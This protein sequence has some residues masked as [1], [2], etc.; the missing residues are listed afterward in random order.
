MQFAACGTVVRVMGRRWGATTVRPGSRRPV[1]HR[2]GGR[3]RALGFPRQ[4]SRRRQPV[5]HGSA[6]RTGSPSA[7]CTAPL[8]PAA[9]AA[10]GTFAPVLLRSVC[11]L[12]AGAR[13]GAGLRA[14]RARVPAAARRRRASS[15]CVRGLPARRAWVPGLAFGIGFQFVLLF[16]MRAVGIG[17]WLALAGSRPRSWHRSGAAAAVLL[18]RRGGAVVVRRRLGGGRD[19]P[20]GLAVQR[21]AL[22]PAVLRRRRD[23]AGRTPCPTSG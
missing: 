18:R 1:P 16:W 23:A 8:P 14:R 11:A 15:L 5:G 21:D 2:E 20:L 22:G 10:A 4:R 19:D 3:G 17:P 7:P 6:R 12:L 13:A 9:L